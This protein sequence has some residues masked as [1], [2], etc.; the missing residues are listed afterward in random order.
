LDSASATTRNELAEI[1]LEHVLNATRTDIGAVLMIPDGQS[2][3]KGIMPELVQL[4]FQVRT[5]GEYEA[6]SESL[7]RRTI[8]ENR[9]VLAH[10]V[11]SGSEGAGLSRPSDSIL[12]IQAR[13]VICA[14][15]RF[16]GQICG[17][18][19]VYSTS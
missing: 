1:V 10:Y 9:A 11:L 13:S 5:A 12:E 3:K 19:H 6:I 2:L 7:T 15:I 18:L 4:A 14:P 8:A 17:L 16:G